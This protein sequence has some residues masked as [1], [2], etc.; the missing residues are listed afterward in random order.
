MR[1]ASDLYILSISVM[2][3]YTKFALSVTNA[4]LVIKQYA[5]YAILKP[6][7]SAA[8]ILE[9]GGSSQKSEASHHLLL[10]WSYGLPRKYS[11]A[12]MPSESLR[13]VERKLLQQIRSCYEDKDRAPSH[14]LP[15]KQA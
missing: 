6:A 4:P 15:R 5:M 14:S 2:R 3:S 11:W 7:L 13:P 12:M 8:L 9:K 1:D 10:G